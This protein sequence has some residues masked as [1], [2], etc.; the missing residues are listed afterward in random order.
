MAKVVN[1][2]RVCQSA[3]SPTEVLW[4]IFQTKIFRLRKGTDPHSI[5]VLQKKKIDF[6]CSHTGLH[7][8]PTER[9]L[10]NNNCFTLIHKDMAKQTEKITLIAAKYGFLTEKFMLFVCALKLKMN[11]NTIFL[12]D[13]SCLLTS[14]TFKKILSTEHKK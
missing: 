2:S 10:I 1:W 8:K 4:K 11:E 13:F 14:N 5:V 12:S 9:V 6:Y 7:L 3:L